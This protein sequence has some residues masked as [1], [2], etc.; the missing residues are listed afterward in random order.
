M[1]RDSQPPQPTPQAKGNILVCD[2]SLE[3]I[4][5]LVGMLKRANYRLSISTNGKD[6]CIRASVLQPDLILMDVRMPMMDGFAACRVLKAHPDT[7][8][9]PLIFLTAANEVEDRVEGLKLGG[10]DYIVK[11]A[12]EEEV[13]LRVGVHVSRRTGS[14]A[15]TDPPSSVVDADQPYAALVAATCRLLESQ[16]SEALS[17]DEIASKVGTHRHRLTTAFKTAFGTTVFGWLRERRMQQAADWLKHTNMDIEG[18]AQELGFV[19]PGNFSTAFRHRFGMAP[20]EYRRNMSGP[21]SP[22][23]SEVRFLPSEH[24]E[25]A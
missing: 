8:D 14:A 25:A 4:R 24:G 19:S 3:E 18:I 12:D 5:V 17:I 23:R 10:V 11:P 13:L 1:E 22:A 20:R 9:I 2:D 7:R 21:A 16:L 15:I 6:A